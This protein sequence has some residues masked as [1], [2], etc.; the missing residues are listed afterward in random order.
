MMEPI[1][2]AA[3]M[4]AAL[5]AACHMALVLL[6]TPLWIGLL[7]WMATVMEGERRPPDPA[8]HWRAL[9]RAWRQ[10]GVR[11][12]AGAHVTA[13]APWLALAAAMGA[14]ILVP[15]FSLGLPGSDLSDL[16]VVGGLLEM[17]FL[18]LLVVAFAAGLPRPGHAG[19]RVA[20]GG[21]MLQP[22]LLLA[23]AIL[24]MCLPDGTLAGLVRQAH[25][26]DMNLIRMPLALVAGALV[27]A[28]V[29]EG[30]G[31]GARLFSI[32]L[33]D[34][35]GPDRAVAQYARDLLAV[36][37]MMLARDLIWPESIVEPDLLAHARIV[38]PLA[39]AVV[40]WGVHMLLACGCVAGMRVF[41][42]SGPRHATW[43]AGLGLLC[44]IMAGVLLFAGRGMG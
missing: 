40:L 17:A 6:T 32:M 19:L 8:A 36:V 22:V 28:G 4:Q 39:W 5:L 24:G 30:N 7:R 37:W 15:S 3:R 18:A 25:V 12:A 44:A 21:F 11:S 10:P 41:V 43:R 38:G 31:P 26:A 33:D 27:L 16:L 1:L 42:L 34:L 35:A 9:R 29:E 2:L 20:T 14:A 13:L 23:C